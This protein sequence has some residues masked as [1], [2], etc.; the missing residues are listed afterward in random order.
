MN[1]IIHPLPTLITLLAAAL[2]WLHGPIA[3][4]PH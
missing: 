4:P 3:Q 2:L 1:A